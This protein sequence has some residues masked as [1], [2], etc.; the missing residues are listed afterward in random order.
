MTLAERTLY[1][2]QQFNDWRDS[3]LSGAAFCRQRVLSYHQ[4]VYW[5]R[6]LEGS[7][8]VSTPDGVSGAGFARVTQ[9]PPSQESGDLTLRLPG[10]MAITG[11]H[12]GN[13]DLLAAILK[14]L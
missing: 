12:A 4:F 14:Q 6:K 10:G 8:K 2:Q 7:A 11:L 13:V 5:R 3:G 1:W 9:V